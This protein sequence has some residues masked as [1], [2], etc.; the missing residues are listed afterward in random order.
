[1]ELGSNEAIKQA[2]VGGLGVSVL[3]RH[4]LPPDVTTEQ[5]ALLDVRGFPIER[6]WHVAYPKG[7]QLSVVAHTFLDYLKQ[8]HLHMGLTSTYGSKANTRAADG[9]SGR[10]NTAG[11][12][13]V[14]GKVKSIKRKRGSGLNENPAPVNELK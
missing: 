2:V 3:S 1:M 7:K 4:T 5:I 12:V 10:H 6:H 14:T 9:R 8:A 11:G 13:D